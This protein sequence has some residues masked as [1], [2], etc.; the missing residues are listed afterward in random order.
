M[1]PSTRYMF[2]SSRCLRCGRL[3]SLFG[4][5]RGACTVCAVRRSRA[6]VAM[7]AMKVLPQYFQTDFVQRVTDFCYQ[8][9]KLTIARAARN[10]WHRF[11][12]D[13]H[14][15]RVW[16]ENFTRIRLTNEE[17]ETEEGVLKSSLHFLNPMWKLAVC[18]GA[19]RA[20]DIVIDMLPPPSWK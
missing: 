9:L 16:T 2:R 12:L 3:N 4:N 17:D 13:R 15:P 19:H 6:I 18:G 7:I 1:N 11:L 10:Y 5:L 14:M 20:L 8:G